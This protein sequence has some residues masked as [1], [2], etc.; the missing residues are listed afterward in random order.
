MNQTMHDHYDPC[1]LC[2][3]VYAR[4]DMRRAERIL[5][6]DKRGWICRSCESRRARLNITSIV[7]AENRRR[8]L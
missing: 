4:G 3:G 7:M 5:G 6:K 2:K 8:G 1:R